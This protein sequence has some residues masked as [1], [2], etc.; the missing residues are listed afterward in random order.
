MK[1]ISWFISSFQ[2]HLFMKQYDNRL[3]LF[4]AMLLNI[5]HPDNDVCPPKGRC[6]TV[7][8]ES[9]MELLRE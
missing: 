2:L 8:I 7:A 4:I 5:K 3:N 9:H 6:Q 1:R